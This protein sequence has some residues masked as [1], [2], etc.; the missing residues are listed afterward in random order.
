MV[1]MTSDLDITI[2]SV[3]ITMLQ[4]KQRLRNAA[5]L[6]EVVYLRPVL[7]N[8]TLWFGKWYMLERFLYV[9]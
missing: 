2:N 1:R 5:L 9:Y 7:Q 8:Q 4:C 6:R 3:H